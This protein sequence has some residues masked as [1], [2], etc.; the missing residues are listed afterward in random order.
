[1]VI[2]IPVLTVGDSKQH[3]AQSPRAWIQSCSWWVFKQVTPASASFTTYLLS[4]LFQLQDQLR[5]VTFHAYVQELCTAGSSEHDW[6][7]PGMNTSIKI[8]CSLRELLFLPLLWASCEVSHLM[9]N[10]GLMSWRKITCHP[11]ESCFV[12]LIYSLSVL[13][14]TNVNRTLIDGSGTSWELWVA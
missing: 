10:K 14:L 2:H 3:C 4:G 6:R 1:M 7:W 8:R 12:R 5:K 13:H 9:R 11:G